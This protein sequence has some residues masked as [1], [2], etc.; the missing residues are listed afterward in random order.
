[1]KK[2]WLLLTLFLMACGSKTEKVLPVDEAVAE[3]VLLRGNGPEPESMDPHLATSVGA[4]NVLINLFEGLTRIHSETLLPEPGMAESWE[5]SEDGLQIDFFL[6]DA[7]WS[8]GTAVSAPDFEFAFKRL[9]NPDLG[10]SYAFMLYPI[11]NAKEVN[12]GEKE[13]D[14]LGVRAL[15]EKTLRLQ[16][17]EPTPYIFGLLAHWTAFPLPAHVLKEFESESSRDG[18]WTRPE[19][20]VVNGAFVLKEWRGEDRLILAKNEKYWQA[21]TVQLQGAEFL[22][23]PDAAS[24]E[25]AFRAGEIHVTYTLPRHRLRSYQKKEPEHLRVDPY[26]ESVGYAMNLQHEALKDVRVRKALSLALD[27]KLITETVLY[28][29]RKPAF[30]YVPPGTAGYQ[31]DSLL[32]ED[33]DEARRLLAEAGYPGGEHFPEVIFIYQSGQDSQKVAELI[34]QRW[35]QELGIRIEIENLE[36]QTYYSRRRER[37]FDLCYLGWVGDYVDPLTFMGLWQ[38][39]AGNNL[40][41][42]KDARYDGLLTSSAQAGGQRMEVLAEA[43]AVLLEAL[44]ILPLYFG[45]TQYLKD[46]R[47]KGWSANLLDWHPLRAVSFE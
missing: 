13:L 39:E 18:A 34:Q 42:W 7:Q 5:V 25:N 11:L 40:A 6:R 27:R 26:L 4:G 2:V 28:G 32:T 12:T 24:E 46:P 16:L 36:R 43:E 41:G 14:D 10:A 1:M 45:A 47:V 8:D 37:D 35:I 29:V 17:S 33:A 23:I 15:D 9:L 3:G 30:S 31:P 22:S 21:E 44:P 38:S 19:N 20:L